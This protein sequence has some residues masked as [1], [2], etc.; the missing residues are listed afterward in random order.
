MRLVRSIAAPLIGLVTFAWR[1]NGVVRIFDIR[2]F[3]LLAPSAIVSEFLERP[4][5][6]IENMRGDR[7]GTWRSA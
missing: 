6:Y 7:R 4:S 5:F 3:V 1:G 2:R